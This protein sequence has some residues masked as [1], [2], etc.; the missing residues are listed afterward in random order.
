MSRDEFRSVVFAGGGNRCTWQA[1]FWE[2]VAPAWPLKPRVVAAVSAGAAIACCCLA[3]TSKKALA[4]Y[5][6]VLLKNPKNFYFSR[7]LKGQRPFPHL[8]IY[9][10]ALLTL[11]DEKE[12]AVL[13]D[14]PEM[15]ILLAR[16]PA[17]AGSLGGV[18]LGF[19]AYTLEKHLTAP[20][21]PVLP[22]KLGFVPEVVSM[23]QCQTPAQAADLLLATA[24]TP[25][26]LPSMRLNGGPVLD[27]GLIDNVPLAAL[28]PED[29]PSLILLSRR[30]PPEK[31]I[32]HPGRTYVQPSVPVPAAKW[33][34]TNPQSLH[35]A[36]DLGLA[37]GE[38]F[39]ADGPEALQR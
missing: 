25:P 32:G 30:Y 36:F 1:G 17:W 35:D 23:N 28:R 10:Q 31:L 38:K 33:D 15:R 9:R 7:L 4:H 39:L 22:A 34:Y 12:L 20:L 14:G 11:L 18:L 16:P 8:A 3:G 5:D 2:A 13:R 6:V 29:S 21:H 24:S 26:V 19:L 27:G 37:D